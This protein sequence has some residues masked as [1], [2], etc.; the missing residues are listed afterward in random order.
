VGQI[1]KGTEQARLGCGWHCGLGGLL[2]D[3]AR[4]EKK[5]A[6]GRASVGE[7]EGKGVLVGLDSGEE[8]GKEFFM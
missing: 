6:L 5:G 4:E 2:R 1:G 3:W 7:E 8:R